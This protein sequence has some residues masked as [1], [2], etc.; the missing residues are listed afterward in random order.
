MSRNRSTVVQGSPTVLVTGAGRGLG[1]VA[2]VRLAAAGWRVYAG[3]RNAADAQRMAEKS[4][5]TPVIVD[6]TNEE[7]LAQLPSQ[8]PERLDALVSNA[9]VAVGGPIETLTLDDLRWQL[10]VNVIGA[11]GVTQAVLPLIR[12]AHGRIVF[13]SSTSGRVATPSLGA[14]GASK[15]ALE[16][17]GDSLRNELR[18]WGIKVSL[19]EPGQ[20]DTDMSKGSHEQHDENIAKMSTGHQKLYA[21]HSEGMHKAIDLMDG[22][23]S[24][25]EEIT[26]AIERALTDKRPRAR[27]LVGKG[28]RA[29][30]YTR[31]LPSPMADAIFS[32]ATGIPKRV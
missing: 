7:H 18:P 31:I 15:F 24:S 19:I 3:V 25:P 6:V 20:I 32:R 27:Y 2:A 28:S 12:K 16:A 4:N 17:I 13:I 29:H 1:Y 22:V 30:A 5:V 21:K 11:V 8:L 9:G 26:V 23:I 14:Y 10:D